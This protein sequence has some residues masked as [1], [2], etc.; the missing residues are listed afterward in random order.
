MSFL[1]PLFT[2]I[3]STLIIFSF[4]EVYGA[5]IK[6]YKAV[7]IIVAVM[8]V[9]VGFRKSV[10]ADYPVYER[11]YS[12]Y[13]I[14]TDYGELFQKA[15][16]RQSTIEI[17]W[18]YVLFNNIYFNL[19]FPFFIFTFAVAICSLTPKF[20]VLEKNVAY[21]AF[22]LLLY[23][24]PSYFIAD[25]GHIR[26][27]LGMAVC[28]LSFQFIKSRNLPMFLLMIFIALGF[29]KSSMVFLPA[30]WIAVIPMNSKKIL[31]AVAV[32]AA[33]APFQLYNSLGFLNN[34]APV[35]VYA[36][37]EGYVS[38]ENEAGRGVGF[39]DLISILY[40]YYIVV[41][42]KA[43]CA[44]IPYYEYMRN[45][46]VFGI[47]LYFIMRGSPIFSTRLPGNYLF[48]MVL[49]L[50]NI[51]ASITDINMKK[52]LH[53]VLVCF[54]VFYYFVFSHYQA[55]AGRFVPESYQ[56]YLWSN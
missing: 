41:Y 14:G 28:A 15:L 32:C 11:M 10:G 26:Q 4:L 51:I 42:D 39:L 9:V 48:Y 55:R 25:S 40:V 13:G 52:Y 12:Y 34:I 18:L 7:W 49:I 30:Y 16:L 44:K 43:T 24:I 23:F 46:G 5:E 56:N 45:L 38:I 50:P 29:H 22:A 3:F 35:E 31:I 54:M 27:A 33:L 20:Y 19:G 2:L 6:N 21:P 36:G 37:Y 53:F 17:E 47:C 1:H 8:I